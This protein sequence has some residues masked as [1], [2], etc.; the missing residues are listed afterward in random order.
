MTTVAEYRQFAEECIVWA[1]AAKSDAERQAFLDMARNWT[2][3]ASLYEGS[4]I[5]DY[6]PTAPDNFKH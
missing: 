2:Q 3:A 4:P 1:R 6:L 5:T